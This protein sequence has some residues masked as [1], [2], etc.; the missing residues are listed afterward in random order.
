MS[1][2]DVNSV[3]CTEQDSVPTFYKTNC[4]NKVYVAFLSQMGG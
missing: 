2:Y 4:Y 3:F 1:L